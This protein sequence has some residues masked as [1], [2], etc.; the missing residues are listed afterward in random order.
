MK[1]ILPCIKH[2][3]STLLQTLILHVRYDMCFGKQSTMK[4]SSMSYNCRV[5]SIH[6]LLLSISDFD[7]NPNLN[8]KASMATKGF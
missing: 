8:N 2:D 1:I 4:F 5:E 6:F 7:L 3:E